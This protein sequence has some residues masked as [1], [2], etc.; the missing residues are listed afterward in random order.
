MKMNKSIIAN[1]IF[2]LTCGMTG[3]SQAE[4]MVGNDLNSAS[5]PNSEINALYSANRGTKGGGDQSLQFGDQ[6]VGTYYDDVLI[7]GLGIDVLFGKEGDDILLGGTED[8]NGL[9]RD[10]AFGNAGNDIF[11]WTPGDGNDF[12]DGGA[13]EDVLVMAVVGELRNNDDVETGVPNFSVNPPKP[14]L[15][16]DG[17]QD[18]DGIFLDENSLPFVNIQ[19]G[20]GFCDVLD[21]ATPGLSELNLDHLV[22]FT[23]KKAA[24]SFDAEVLAKPSVDQDTLDTGLRVAVHLKNTEFVVC[25]SRNGEEIEVFDLRSSPIEKISVNDL[26]LKAY[27]LVLKEIPTLE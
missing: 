16:E 1:A 13:G 12:F 26:P 3:T 19:G 15:D 18:F 21:T 22:R 14:E 6:I 7:G 23:L 4:V 20:P 25:S 27:N 17:S 9:N 2:L 5:G 11:I 10:R 24:N 8:F